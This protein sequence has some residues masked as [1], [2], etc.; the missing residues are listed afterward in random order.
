[1]YV[2]VHIYKP[3]QLIRALCSRLYL[4]LIVVMAV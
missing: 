4:N 1:M 2:Y 3:V